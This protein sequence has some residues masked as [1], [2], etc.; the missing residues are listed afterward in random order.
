MEKG[1]AMRVRGV[2]AIAI[3]AFAIVSIAGPAQALGPIQTVVTFKAAAGEFPEG[4][5]V[6]VRGTA[7]V[8]LIAPVNE[9]RAIDPSGAQSVLAHFNVTP[10][11]PLGL[12]VNAR[13][14]LYVAMS[15]FDPSTRGVYRVFPDGTSQRLPGTD[16]L[17]FPNGLAIDPRGNIYATDSIGGSVWKIPPGGTATMWSQDPSLAGTGA[18]GLGFP[19]GANG[20]AFRNNAVIVANTEGGKIVRFPVKPDGTAGTASVVAEGQSLFGADGVALDVFGNIF[21]ADNPQNT[22]LRV[23]ANGSSITT[24]A[25]AADGL[26]NPASLSFGTS[27]GDRMNLFITNFSVF[28]QAPTPA[29]FKMAVGVP[30]A[31]V[32]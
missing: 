9:I 17:Q 22:L 32:T 16:Q 4:V 2:F 10:F 21:V 19:L 13:G 1:Q 25:T 23:S 29:L 7:Y 26:N 5:A 27:M 14:A 15:T 6:D 18:L 12:V 24:L 20:I 31:P 11:G 30:G 3:L 28:S 8:S